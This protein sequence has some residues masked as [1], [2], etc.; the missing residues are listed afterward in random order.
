MKRTALIAGVV[1]VALVGGFLGYGWWTRRGPIEFSEGGAFGAAGP[2]ASA[3]ATP[4]ATS[5]AEPRA[6]GSAAPSKEAGARTTRGSRRSVV[7]APRAGSL[8]A[9]APGTYVFAGT[10]RE[11]VEFGPA[12]A[13]GWDID[14]VEMVAKRDG[15][16]TVLDWVWSDNRQQRGIY[17]FGPKGM[18]HRYYGAVATCVGV[19][20]TEEGDYTPPSVR[21]P[22][23]VAVG[24]RW[25]STSRSEGWTEHMRGEVLRRERVRVPAGT[26]DA[27]VV[28]MRVTFSEGQSGTFEATMWYAPSIAFWVKERA[29]TDIRA[30]GADFTSTYSVELVEHPG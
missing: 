16:L 17:D 24:V 29:Q 7:G 26:F 27:Y 14:R 11:D 30:S 23:D 8:A 4:T 21:L 18:R 3:A 22:G 19:R 2:S 6:T 9:P 25:T 1:V 13:C 12:S 10:G 20:R 5:R 15:D 28:H